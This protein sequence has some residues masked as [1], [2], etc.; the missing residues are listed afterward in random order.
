MAAIWVPARMFRGWWPKAA[1]LPKRSK[2]LKASPEKS[3]NPA[4]NTAIRS[5]LCSGARFGRSANSGF[6]FLSLKWDASQDFPT[7]KLP[8]VSERFGLQFDRPGAGSHEV[9][10]HPQ[11]GR[12]VTLPHH[13]GDMA[14]GT[15]RAILREAG[16]NVNDFLKA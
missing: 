14:E 2:S 7:G 12:K 9:W 13:S 4:G 8:A 10:R 15:L 5:P 6:L 16:I 3:W 11:T 1:A